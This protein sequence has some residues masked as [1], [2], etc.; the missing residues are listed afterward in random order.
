M[1][2][3]RPPFHRR[4]P[5]PKQSEDRFHGRLSAHF[6]VLRSNRCVGVGPEVSYIS[7]LLLIF[8]VILV[9]PVLP[10]AYRLLGKVPS[11]LTFSMSLRTTS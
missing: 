6:F 7:Q 4:W 9:Q 2:N 10:N 8:S 3:Y 5:V 11:F 1:S